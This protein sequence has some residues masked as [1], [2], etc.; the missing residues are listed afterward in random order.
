MMQPV[1]DQKI[2]EKTILRYE[3]VLHQLKSATKT[4]EEKKATDKSDA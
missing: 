1:L 2:L 4:I 3:V